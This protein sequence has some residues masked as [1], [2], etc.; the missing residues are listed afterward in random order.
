[1]PFY[2]SNIQDQEDLEHFSDFIEQILDDEDQEKI[3]EAKKSEDALTT[4]LND[5][6][7]KIA[8]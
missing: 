5:E 6:H 2:E 1:M 4:I 8:E 3:L 7:A